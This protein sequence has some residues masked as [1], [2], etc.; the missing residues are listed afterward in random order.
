MLSDQR[1]WRIADGTLVVESDKLASAG[2]LAYAVGD[3][4]RG[5]DVARIEALAAAAKKPAAK[6][7]PKADDKAVKTSTNK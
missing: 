5:D 7:A 4:V 1:Y 2:T 3:E 6:A